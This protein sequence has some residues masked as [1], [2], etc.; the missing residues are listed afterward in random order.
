MSF[1][2]CQAL[3]ISLENARKLPTPPGVA[4]RVVE[5]CRDEDVPLDEIATIFESDPALASRL[6]KYVNSPLLGPGRSIR[7][8]RQA[9]SYA[10]LKAARSIA[11]GFT[12]SRADY[13]IECPRFSLSRFWKESF[14][15]AVVARQVSVLQHAA[16]RDTAFITGLL[17]GIGRLLL[18]IG[19]PQAYAQVF[20]RLDLGERL[21]DA[22]R[23][24]IG[25]DHAQFGGALLRNWGLPDEITQAVAHQFA[26]ESA[27]PKHHTLARTVREGRAL[28]P[29]FVRERPLAGETRAR[30]RNLVETELGLDES[31][32]PPVAK[33]ILE[34]LSEV[35]D[36]FD[37]RIEDTKAWLDIYAQV[38]DEE[39]REAA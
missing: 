3:I 26:P 13:P 28:T 1:D 35:G 25:V 39:E 7:T 31:S 5:L 14:A 18:A 30:I 10:G 17:S 29:V 34:G 16:D 27:E 33:S 21:L 38:Q 6:L 20:E 37:V 11:L 8:V 12:L 19:V 9:I 32:W 36:I 15:T 4:L 23:E 24:I 2:R 22:E